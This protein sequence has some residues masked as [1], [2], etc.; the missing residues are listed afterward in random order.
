MRPLTDRSREPYAVSNVRF[1]GFDS[2][3]ALGS[4][5][6]VKDDY[7][8]SCQG[9][10]KIT[11]RKGA[12]DRNKGSVTSLSPSRDVFGP[13]YPVSVLL[14]VLDSPFGFGNSSGCVRP[15]LAFLPTSHSMAQAP[16]SPEHERL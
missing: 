15:A 5:T 7:L 4:A 13:I 14:S 10:R 9:S 12:S 3:L 2:M 6:C 8:A 11:S 1:E 16:P